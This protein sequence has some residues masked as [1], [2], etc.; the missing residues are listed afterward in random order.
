MADVFYT[1]YATNS[2]A[3]A[4]VIC[5]TLV[6]GTPLNV[7]VTSATVYLPSTVAGTPIV[8][9]VPS[10]A[11]VVQ[12]LVTGEF[13]R[14]SSKTNWVAWSKIGEAK[15]EM[16]KVNDSGLAPMRWGGTVYQILPLE[17]DF[18]VYGSTGITKML[19]VAEPAPTFGFEE[20][21]PFGIQSRYAVAGNRT[22]HYF[23]S[24]DGNLF[25]LT[26]SSGY[27]AVSAD[28]GLKKLGYTE[29]LSVLGANT[30]MFYD[31]DEMKLY[32]SDGSSGFI[33]SPQ[34]FGGG[35][36][37][38][39]GMQLSSLGTRFVRPEDLEN[40]RE[41]HTN[42]IDLGIREVKTL[43]HLTLRTDYPDHW[44]FA[45]YSRYRMN[46]VFTQTPWRAF[47]SYGEGWPYVAGVEFKIAIRS[48]SVPDV[49]EIQDLQMN[50]QISDAAAKGISQ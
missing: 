36:V 34:G 23:I 45:I 37:N 44:E 42:I 2:G 32:I 9:Y 17:N 8:S 14:E 39:T 49:I 13:S 33:L 38:L 50:F 28:N 12:T 31:S 40:V 19:P 3:K 4:A 35:W 26:D 20:I 48:S 46:E 41:F 16:D 7:G 6:T 29:F 21:A 27:K 5:P 47:D 30:L 22:T 10:G 1:F 11:V 18:I 43:D 24:T 25:R 15:I